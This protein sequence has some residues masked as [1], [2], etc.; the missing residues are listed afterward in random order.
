[1]AQVT[2]CDKCKQVVEPEARAMGGKVIRY[3][4]LEMQGHT[5]VTAAGSADRHA[6]GQPHEFDLCGECYSEVLFAVLRVV[7]RGPWAED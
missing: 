6:S 2:Q 1:M 4:R 3:G 7:E 5:T